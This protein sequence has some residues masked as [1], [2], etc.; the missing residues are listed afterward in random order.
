M[1]KSISD[2]NK[3]FVV[4]DNEEV[5]MILRKSLISAGYQVQVCSEPKKAIQMIKSFWPDVLV[6][7]LLMP[8]VGGLEICEM[9]NKDRQTQG[10]P[11][12]VASGLNKYADIKKAYCSGTVCYLAKPFRMTELLEEINKFLAY[13]SEFPPVNACSQREERSN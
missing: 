10:I 2:K 4:D 1:N 6:L 11:I 8:D 5:L 9:L 7:D 3:V 12:I 13:K